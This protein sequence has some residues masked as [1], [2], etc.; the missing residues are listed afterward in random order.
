VL[1]EARVYANA[2]ERTRGAFIPGFLE[3]WLGFA[4]GDLVVVV[5]KY[6]GHTLEGWAKRCLEKGT[7]PGCIARNFAKLVPKLADWSA[8]L[9]AAHEAVSSCVL[10]LLTG[11]VQGPGRL[12]SREGAG[13]VAR[14]AL[15]PGGCLAT[16]CMC[17][18]VAVACAPCIQHCLPPSDEAWRVRHTVC[19]MQDGDFLV[20]TTTMQ[21]Q[22]PMRP[23]LYKAAVCLT[24]AQS[25]VWT[26]TDC[27]CC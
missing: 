9:A 23:V 4:C 5:T 24:T 26:C 25:T 17:G 11:T 3:P 18:V 6:H 22:T 15:L 13:G 19:V 21:S 27:G 1:S 8:A 12:C 14:Q 20:A 7:S 16:W 10:R 2:I